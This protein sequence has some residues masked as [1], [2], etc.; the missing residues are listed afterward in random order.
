MMEL[1]RQMT[2]K[3]LKIGT[4]EN[5]TSMKSLS[6]VCY[7]KL[8]KYKIASAYKLCAIS[9]ASGILSNYRRL[10]KKG[11]KVKLPYCFKPSLVTCYGIR[12]R[13][14]VLHLP[15][16][17]SIPLNEYALKKLI[18]KE[19]RSVTIHPEGVSISYRQEVKR[20]GCGGVIGI[21]TNLENVTVADNLRT[22]KNLR[23]AVSQRPRQSTA[24]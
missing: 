21:D 6:L 18:A 5:K 1:F 16:K 23:C 9:R 12:L 10:V 3:C 15:S 24:K 19:I 22:T 14:G 20:K 11:R 2:N 17:I 13:N 8:G 7:G 4:E